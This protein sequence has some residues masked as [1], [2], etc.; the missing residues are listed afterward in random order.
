MI[1]SLQLDRK[2]H[3]I[4]LLRFGA[5]VSLGGLIY[6]VT[7]VSVTLATLAAYS[8]GVG[9]IRSNVVWASRYFYSSVDEVS[10][11]AHILGQRVFGK[12]QLAIDILGK[13]RKGSLM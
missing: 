8:N 1:L 4:G 3:Q 12:K 9:E 2:S 7:V 11:C 10:V 5:V 13:N 6:T